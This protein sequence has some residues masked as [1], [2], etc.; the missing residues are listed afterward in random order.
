M[1]VE[2]S[3]RCP[4][5]V[6]TRPATALTVERVDPSELDTVARILAAAYAEDPI[7]IWA[8]PKAAA[9]LADAT[10]FFTFFLRRMRPHSWD[11]FGTADRSAVLVTS[12][13]LQGKSP[14]PDVVRYL[15]TLVRTMS[16]VND[17]FQWIE[18]F[19]PRVDHQYF[20]FLGALPN[21]PRGTGFFLVANVLK[22]FDRQGL[23]VWTWSSN[24][25]NLP[26]F[27]RQGFQ[28]GPELRQN[29]S[30][31]VVTLIWRPPM[32]AVPSVIV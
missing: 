4:D 12:L 32:P 18:T 13:V 14:Y 17:Y 2:R 31:P 24:P 10:A 27:R 28:I 9:Q 30:T 25:L 29:A 15:P 19:R 16:P 21:A 3:E 5:N 26:F 22:I 1:Q 7:H 11:V 8:M 6:V 20:E 23:P